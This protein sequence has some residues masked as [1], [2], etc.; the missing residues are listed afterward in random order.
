MASLD[1][2]NTPRLSNKAI[3]KIAD[4]ALIQLNP[5]QTIPVPI[6]QAIEIVMGYVIIPC[7]DLQSISGCDAALAIKDKEIYIDEDIYMSEKY[8]RYK[9][10]LAHELGHIILHEDIFL[11]LDSYDD[12][13]DF[14]KKCPADALYW[15]EWQA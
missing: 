8:K 1:D 2:I 10:T 15:L 7:P 13:I 12:D 3:L 5:N 4:E 9:F 6:D 14:H 11:L